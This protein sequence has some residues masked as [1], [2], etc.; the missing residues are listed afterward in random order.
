MPSP[1][2]VGKTWLLL[3]LLTLPCPR[4]ASPLHPALR[5]S[6]PVETGPFAPA[7]TSTHALLWP[8]LSCLC[9]LPKSSA[10]PQPLLPQQG[11]PPPRAALELLAEGTSL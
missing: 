7:G 6:S 9:P 3:V 8:D 2:P 10:P 11:S 4:L 1:W 5:P